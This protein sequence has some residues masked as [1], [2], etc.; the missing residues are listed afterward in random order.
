MK[1]LELLL[2]DAPC[3]VLGEALGELFSVSFSDV[4]HALAQ[5]STLYYSFHLLDFFVL[6]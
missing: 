1:S 4:L 6:C 2:F 5:G 3:K